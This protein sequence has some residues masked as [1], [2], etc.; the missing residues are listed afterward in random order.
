[1]LLCNADNLTESDQRTIRKDGIVQDHL[2]F[3]A[4]SEYTGLAELSWPRPAEVG[5]H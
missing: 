1:M 5:S 3:G 4:P 2:R